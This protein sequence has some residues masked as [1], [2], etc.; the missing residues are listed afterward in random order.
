MRHR[1]L[2]KRGHLEAELQLLERDLKRAEERGTACKQQ[3][4]EALECADSLETVRQGH[5]ELGFPNITFHD[6][7]QLDG[8]SRGTIVLGSGCAIADE[9]VRT[10]TVE[11][12][13]DGELISV[14]PHSSLNLQHEA[15]EVVKQ[16]DLPALL[17]RVWHRICDPPEKR[18]KSSRGG[19]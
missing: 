13:K 1:E 17:T 5:L 7:S 8:A 14:T 10:V 19:A 15:A 18:R 16:D 2:E 11:F 12:G 9:A 6:D 3:H 4:K